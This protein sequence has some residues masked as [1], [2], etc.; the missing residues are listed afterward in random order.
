MKL[1]TCGS[2]KSLWS[3]VKRH[4]RMSEEN[5]Y[6]PIQRSTILK[7][8]CGCRR[9]WCARVKALRI[10]NGAC[11][12]DVVAPLDHKKVQHDTGLLGVSIIVD[13]RH[14]GAHDRRGRRCSRKAEVPDKVQRCGLPYLSV[15]HRTSSLPFRPFTLTCHPCPFCI[16]HF[17]AFSVLL[18]PSA[19]STYLFPDCNTHAFVRR[20]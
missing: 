17:I 15:V 19:P 1:P 12:K 18:A 3:R 6:R 9:C 10:W 13:C 11:V 4:L 8:S 2:T 7:S 14:K 5:A 20:H 16:E